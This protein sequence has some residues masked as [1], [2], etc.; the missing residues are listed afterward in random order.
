MEHYK[1]E[2]GHPLRGKVTISG[3][4]NAAVAIIPAVILCNSACRLENI[5]NIEDVAI[6]RNILSS[7]GAEVDFSDN[8]FTAN[9]VTIHTNEA[10][11]EDM[12]K[13][14]ASYYLLGALLGRYG[15]AKI[16]YPG[17]CAIGERP[18]DL[19]IKGL[20]RL[21]AVMDFDKANGIITAKAHTLVGAEI[22][23]D[24]ASVGATIN[25]MLAA[26]CA[27][28]TTEIHNAAKEP[29]VVDVANFLNMCGARIK[30][31]G[32]D[33]IRIVGV[34]RGNLH[35]CS[36]AIIPDQIE[37]GT[38]MI[39]AA[40]TGGEVVIKNIIPAHLEAITAK[41]MEAGVSVDPAIEGNDYILNVA[42]TMRPRPLRIETCTYPGFPTDL[43]QPMMAFLSTARGESIIIDKI[44]TERFNHVNELNK[45]GANMRV[46]GN[47]KAEI[48]GV[49]SLHGADIYA[50]DLRAGAA[51]IIA[52]LMAKG[53]T[54]VYNLH[55]T[56]RGYENLE[57]KLKALGARIKR[58]N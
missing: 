53:E 54:R 24:K 43:Q 28:G 31:A 12:T 16:A 49:E 52:A 27:E 17:G 34:G 3:A 32:T 39:A 50:T 22:Y 2:G 5:P 7:L 4:K 20:S 29:H 41:L 6:L 45:M 35:G 21:G 57:E 38:F 30:G 13:L 1:I 14:R 42:S 9:P 48:I 44:F 37:A 18:I 33:T 40:A 55:Y 26:S 10:L 51:L 46:L 56:D 19:H 11:S 36:Y 47:G 58:V 23:L 25:I 15:Y 8:V